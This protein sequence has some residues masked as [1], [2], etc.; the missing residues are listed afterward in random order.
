MDAIDDANLDR[1]IEREAAIAPALLARVAVADVGRL[2]H[3]DQARADVGVRHAVRA[4]VDRQP[5]EPH[6]MQMRAVVDLAGEVETERALERAR[7]VAEERRE[8]IVVRVAAVA[9]GDLVAL[10]RTGGEVDQPEPILA[11]VEREVDDDE[12]VGL[13]DLRLVDVEIDD[14]V[15]EQP[16]WD[17]VGWIERI[18]LAHD[19]R[20]RCGRQLRQHERVEVDR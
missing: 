11:G 10:D 5:V 3:D 12:I 6:R 4:A 19:R 13:R 2:V 14:R 1:R 9:V 18:V 7:H 20:A 8:A 15:F 16:A 17:L